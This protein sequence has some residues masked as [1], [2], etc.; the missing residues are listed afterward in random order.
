MHPYNKH[1]GPG[2]II[3]SRRISLQTLMKEYLRV[4]ATKFQPSMLPSFS[5]MSMKI[6]RLA[7][8]GVSREEFIRDVLK[9]IQRFGEADEVQL[10]FSRGDHVTTWIFSSSGGADS[11][12]IRRASVSSGTEVE[13][14]GS[15]LAGH[16]DPEGATREARGVYWNNEPARYVSLQTGDGDDLRQVTVPWPDAGSFL[17]LP[18]QMSGRSTAALSLIATRRHAFSL[19][20]AEFVEGLAHTLGAAMADRAAQ[21]ALRERVKEL[22]CLYELSQ[23]AQRRDVEI[24][25]ILE[26]TVDILPAAFQYP[27]LAV[28]RIRFDDTTFSSPSFRE[29]DLAIRAPI[30]VDGTVRGAVEVRYHARREEFS[31]RVFLD[32]EQ[33]LLDAVARQIAL[34][35]EGKQAEQERRELEA[36]LRHADRLATIGE[37]AAGVAH[38]INEP[39]GNILGFAQ[40]MEKDETLGD[41][42]RHDCQRIIHASLHAREIVRKL[43]IFA[44]Q[45]QTQKGMVDLNR[46]VEDGLYF[47]ESRCFRY[48]IRLE[49]RLDAAR[50]CI[51]ADEAQINQVLVNLVVNAIQ[52]LPDGGNITV[53]T[54]AEPR[55]VAVVVEDTGPGLDEGTKDRIFMPFFTTKE[56]GEG[57]GLGLSVVHGI[58]SA[59]GG[60]VHAE[61]R[62]DGGARFIVEF[63]LTQ[64]KTE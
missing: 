28:A 21:A 43:L 56:P 10:A 46:V 29:T 19:R 7:N 52:A 13:L 4:K 61:N 47:L 60:S 36:Q 35:V 64:E 12:S 38:E 5:A 55:H 45:V 30:T 63:P 22:G 54:V 37:L 3:D 15:L 34:I 1:F 57:T 23:M 39:L 49:R 26:R 20:D 42:S 32:E 53:I 44:R 11:L 50:P 62:G 9:T 31:D 17:T 41:Q 40:L 18:V 58:V 25:D 6:L 33:K 16:F 8:R 27:E 48:G 24:D 2:P 14:V 59:H 51:V